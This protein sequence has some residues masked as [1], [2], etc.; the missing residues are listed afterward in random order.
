[1]N[2][3]TKAL[4]VVTAILLVMVVFLWTRKDK[5]QE[6]LFRVG[7]SRD[8]AMAANDTLRKITIPKLGDSLQFLTTRVVQTGVI[9]S[10]ANRALGQKPTTSTTIQGS[11][12]E[13]AV[14]FTDVPV[15]GDTGIRE[16]LATEHDGPYLVS[17]AARVPP[18]PRTAS[19]KVGVQAPPFEL[20]ADVICNPNPER[21]VGGIR[22]ADVMISGPTW[23]VISGIKSS[24]QPGVCNPVKPASK[25]H[26]WYKPRLVAGV[27]YAWTA[28]T[29][30][31]GNHDVIKKGPS[32][33]VG[34]GIGIPLF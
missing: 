15:V 8:S 7:L 26:P 21:A 14:E 18:A 33:F 34:L 31:T 9:P 11:M 2:A 4:G 16:I 13:V 3:V 30:G 6:E 12:K 23:L 27:G 32:A 20:R 10:A 28:T 5:A 17:V 24:Q 1:M 19:I 29:E 22:K 25:Q